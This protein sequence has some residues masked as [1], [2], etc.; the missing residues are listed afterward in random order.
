MRLELTRPIVVADAIDRLALEAL[1]YE[2][3]RSFVPACRDV[4]LLDTDL[5]EEDLISDVL[6]RATFIGSLSHHA[7]VGDNAHS[8]VIRR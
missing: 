4:R 5:A 1:V 7:L 6:S 2:I 8:E 3:C